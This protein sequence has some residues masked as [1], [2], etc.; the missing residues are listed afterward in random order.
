MGRRRT[1][2]VARKEESPAPRHGTIAPMHEPSRRIPYRTWPGALAV[3]LAIA[4]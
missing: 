2:P 1:P 4:A 3:F